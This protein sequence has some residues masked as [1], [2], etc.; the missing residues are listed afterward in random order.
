MPFSTTLQTSWV[1]GDVFTHM[2][3]S[4]YGCACL[5][6]VLPFI[7]QGQLQTVAIMVL[8]AFIVAVQP[9]STG[10]GTRAVAS[11]QLH[12]F[13]TWNNTE[14]GTEH[15]YGVNRARSMLVM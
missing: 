2:W 9:A 5:A 6:F 11:T 14:T 15:D 13:S 12:R 8:S 7:F 3:T 4:A 10:Q 1:S